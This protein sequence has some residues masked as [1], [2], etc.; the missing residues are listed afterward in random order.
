[1][2]PLTRLPRMLLR[3]LVALFSSVTLLHLSVGA[4]DA[5]CAGNGAESHHSAAAHSLAAGHAGHMHHQGRTAA[6]AAHVDGVAAP[7]GSRSPGGSPVQAR[8]CE[9]MTTCSVTGTVVERVSVVNAVPRVSMVMPA[10]TDVA[11]TV[12]QAPEPPPPKA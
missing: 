12:P 9:S 10:P 3:R 6:P 2:T 4:A 5:A 8:C 1:M 11:S 7:L